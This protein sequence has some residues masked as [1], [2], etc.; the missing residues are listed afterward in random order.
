MNK[1]M[2]MRVQRYWHNFGVSSKTCTP[3]ISLT[4]V[5]N[6]MLVDVKHGGKGKNLLTHNQSSKCI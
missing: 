3:T 6:H 2:L 4:Y 5:S 1:F